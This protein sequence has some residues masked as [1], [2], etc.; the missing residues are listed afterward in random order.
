MKDSDFN[1]KADLQYGAD[2]G[3]NTFRNNRM[4]TLNASALGLLRQQI[5]D[6]LPIEDARTV[7]FRFGFQSGYA[8]SL[9]IQYNYDFDTQDDLLEVGPRIHTQKG[10]VD[11]ETI[12][13]DYD[14]DSG[15]FYYNGIWRNS[16]EAQQH[17]AHNRES[18]EPVCWSLIGYASAW[19][20][21]FIEAPV[22]AMESECIGMGHDVCKWEVKPIDQWGSEADPY[23]EALDDLFM[24]EKLM[25]YYSYVEERCGRTGKEE[26]ARH[27]NLPET[28][29]STAPDTKANI[30]MF[31]DAIQNILGERPPRL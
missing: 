25:A 31:R 16:W 17:L 15:E 3:V 6:L 11:V 14:R 28:K 20:S 30:E 27:T 1:L 23:I 9:E 5:L 10:L 12:D 26:L 29:A 22:L 21:G 18:P 2:N 7:L 13:I 19:C 24:G 4:L 8:D